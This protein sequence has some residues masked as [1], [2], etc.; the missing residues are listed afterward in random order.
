MEERQVT[1]EGDRLILEEPFMVLAT[2]NPVEYEGT[3]PLL[4]VQLDRFMFKILVDYPPELVEQEIL[5]RYHHGFD[6]RHLEVTGVER[7]VQP[8]DLGALQAEIRDVTVED[9]C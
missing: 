4:E 9:V 3:Y 7:V 5:R 2:Q 8:A 6:A 1:I